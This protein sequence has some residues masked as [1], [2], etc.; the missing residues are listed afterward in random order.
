VH[1]A[2]DLR[3]LLAD[4]LTERRNDGFDVTSLEP[5][6]AAALAEAS[7]PCDPRLAAPLDS[8]EA[9]VPSDLETR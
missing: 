9:T 7:G 3:D 2:R 8:F 1:D 4:E 5:A 6:V